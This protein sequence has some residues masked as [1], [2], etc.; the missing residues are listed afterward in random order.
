MP[1]ITLCTNESCF[2]RKTCLRADF[3]TAGNNIQQSYSFFIPKNVTIWHA[4]N[5]KD[6]KN[7]VE[8]DYFLPIKDI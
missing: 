3:S 6:N 1:D 7:F 2:A 4:E 5:E 8:C